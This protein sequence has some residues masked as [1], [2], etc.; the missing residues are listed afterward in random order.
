MPPKPQFK[1]TYNIGRAKALKDK[2]ITDP[3]DPNYKP[4]DVPVAEPRASYKHTLSS[5]MVLS[6]EGTQY[7]IVSKLA[8]IPAHRR[9]VKA[10]PDG[11]TER[12]RTDH[13]R[14]G[15][16]DDM[17]Y[18]TITDGETAWEGHIDYAKNNINR[19]LFMVF[20][21]RTSNFWSCDFMIWGCR[22]WESLGVGDSR[23]WLFW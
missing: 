18:M 6:E 3:N 21:S 2:V 4:P 10:D 22:D 16:E 13:V 20:R 8:I 7:T 1:N 19:D 9:Y 12:K 5:S 23:I 14:Y 11:D 17:I 15:P